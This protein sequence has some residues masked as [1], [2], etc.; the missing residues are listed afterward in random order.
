MLSGNIKPTSKGCDTV[1][2]GFRIPEKWNQLPPHVVG[3]PSLPSFKSRLDS[4]Q[5]N[6]VIII[7]TLSI[8]L[9]KL[10]IGFLNNQLADFLKKY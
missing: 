5:F 6:M 7:S 4:L 1:K 9:E 3:A 10:P 8:L 2:P